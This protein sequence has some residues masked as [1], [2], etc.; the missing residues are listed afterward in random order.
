MQQ[1]SSYTTLFYQLFLLE[2]YVLIIVLD[3][4]WTLVKEQMECTGSEIFKSIVPTIERCAS[5]CTGLSSMFAYGTNDFG[6]N[7][8]TTGGCHC[9]CETSA[10][11]KGACSTVKNMGYRLYKYSNRKYIEYR[12]QNYF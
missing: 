10:T 4:G 2:N 1:L 8:C 3:L 6:E 7:R 12:T 9:Y 5:L 11:N